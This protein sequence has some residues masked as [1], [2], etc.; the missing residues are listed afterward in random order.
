MQ[1]LLAIITFIFPYLWRYFTGAHMDGKRRANRQNGKVLTIYR[2]YYWNRYSRQRRAA[3]RHGITWSMLALAFGLVVNKS[4]TMFCV[5]AMVPF[6]LVW[7]GW[8]VRGHLARRMRHVDDDGVEDVYWTLR[9]KYS[10]MIRKASR[11]RIKLRHSGDLPINA[12]LERP[13]LAQLA[14]EGIGD[15]RTL[16]R[17]LDGPKDL[18]ELLAEHGPPKRR[19]RK[20]TGK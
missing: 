11:M 14:E 3:W 12:E 19:P 20:G 2:D 5:L 7:F 10:R 18:D 1:K 17:P 6:V 4:A 9:P 8:K 15:V 16:R 13:I